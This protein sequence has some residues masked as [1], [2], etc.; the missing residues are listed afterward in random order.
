[1]LNE[2][3]L[4]AKDEAGEGISAEHIELKLD[5][6]GDSFSVHGIEQGNDLLVR[7]SFLVLSCLVV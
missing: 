3:E 6:T 5:A 2:G 1:M 4:K 7:D